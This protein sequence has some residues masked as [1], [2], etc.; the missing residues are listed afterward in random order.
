[1]RISVANRYSRR[2]GLGRARRF[3]LGWF[4]VLLLVLGLIIFA[5]NMLGTHRGDLAYVP[6]LDPAEDRVSESPSSLLDGFL[7]AS[8]RN[9]DEIRNGESL[10]SA[11]RRLLVPAREAE[12]LVI[13]LA[14]ELKVQS[15]KPGDVIMVESGSDNIQRGLLG[16]HG[17]E[18][19]P[20]A[21][22]LFTKD[23]NGVAYSVKAAFSDQVDT[24]VKI[25]INKSQVYR[26]H[27]LI[28]GTVN[29][30]IY[31][32]IVNNGGN[33]Q[34]VNSFAD[35]FGWQ[36]DFFRDTHDG[37][38]YQMIVE[39]SVSDG[40]FVGYGRILA[41]EYG[42]ARKTLR[43][44]YFESSDRQVAG[45]FD[46]EGRSLKNA[47][48]KAPLKLAS[49]TS[50]F[51]KRRFHPVQK[52]IKPHNGVDY[53]ANRGTPFMAVA[54]GLIINAGFSVF[55]GNWVRIRHMNGYETEYLHATKLGA[56][57]HVGA[58][59]RQ[60]QVIGYVGKTGLA[61]GYHLHFGMKKDGSYVD[62]VKQNFARSPGVPNKYLREFS[63]NI[64]PM[65]IAL[66]RQSPSKATIVAQLSIGRVGL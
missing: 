20:K 18:M 30:S 62:P 45:F 5:F 15:V 37:D 34:L 48:L 36:I 35:I 17:E 55:N 64:A 12:M 56:G 4:L 32:S 38:S 53:G 42:S 61:S 19:P 66:N 63:S 51:N 16:Q 25:I 14:R 54:S 6:S 59:V 58:R 9:Y 43:G 22:E 21:V 10:S 44:F 1:M 11:L 2:L 7:A 65:V 50:S 39:K 24:G 27:T 52:R 49:I 23:E 46:D 41:A 26:E 40:R 47:F 3:K 29:N 28:N 31:S 57:I 13:A 8:F 60:G 33:A